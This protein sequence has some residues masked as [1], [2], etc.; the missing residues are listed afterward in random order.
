MY[1][2]IFFLEGTAENQRLASAFPMIA[3]TY[4]MLGAIIRRTVGIALYKSTTPIL[5]AYWISCITP[6]QPARGE[7]MT[8]KLSIS[9]T[10]PSR[11]GD[12]RVMQTFN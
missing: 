5:P 9:L 11:R 3:D 4:M 12:S 10:L 2:L 8:A 7:D 6:V 1:N